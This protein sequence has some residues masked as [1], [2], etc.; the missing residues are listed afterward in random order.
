MTFMEKLWG[1]YR[2]TA[3][4]FPVV[5]AVLAP[6]RF[7]YHYSYITYLFHRARGL[8]YR[9]WYALTLDKF[10]RYS[11]A[12]PIEGCERLLGEFQ[13]EYLKKQGLQPDH[14]LLDLGCGNLRAG[15]H[16]IP[17]LDAG[18]YTGTDI[19]A[20]RL[21]QGQRQVKK[22][23]LDQKKPELILTKDHEMKEL[24]GR[25]FDTIWCHGVLGHMPLADIE[26]L[27]QKIHRIM[28]PESA[29]YANYTES[30]GPDEQWVGHRHL[31]FRGET[32]RRLCEKYGLRGETMADW[33]NELRDGQ[34]RPHPLAKRD[35]ML[36]I[37]PAAETAGVR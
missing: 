24:A 19:S 28:G 7:F 37:M 25:T 9:E 10:A 12:P 11:D 26:D 34:G 29:F 14:S 2:R 21:E 8:S 23:N 5:R 22:F 36:K 3:D 17:Y 32:L 4:R 30:D 18:K 16:F 33:H 1:S 13:L 35:R 31:F 20:G 6:I 15:V 27:L